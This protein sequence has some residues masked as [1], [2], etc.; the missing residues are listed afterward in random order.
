MS[1]LA[2]DD[3]EANKRYEVMDGQ[4]VMFARP[5]TPHNCI[6]VNLARIFSN[7]LRGKRC[8]LFIEPDVFLDEKNNLVPDL[9][10]VCRR[11]IIEYDG[12]HG[13]P[14]LVVE[15]LSPR[16][17]R[18]DRFIKK[19]I[20][21][22]AGVKEYWLVNPREKSIEVHH[23]RGGKFVGDNIYHIYSTDEWNL[24]TPEEQAE[25]T[26]KLKVSLYDDLIVDV[27]EVFADMMEW[28]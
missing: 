27:E 7:Y 9:A 1:D 4:A 15:V 28:E 2:Y 21:E 13:A 24:L 8:K 5:A 12:I 16:T 11:E 17:A 14:D 20:Y 23:L 10:I 18:Y 26:L 19:D 6:T 3:F 22:K 25:E